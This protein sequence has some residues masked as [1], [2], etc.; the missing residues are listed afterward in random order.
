MM[1]CLFNF[2]LYLHLMN[3]LMLKICGK[4]MTRKSKFE[5]KYTNWSNGKTLV[6]GVL[7]LSL[8]YL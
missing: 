6:L 5:E 2:L 7:D 3:I 1:K 4:I 8:S